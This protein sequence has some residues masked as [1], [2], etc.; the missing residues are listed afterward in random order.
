MPREVEEPTR[1]EWGGE[2][3]PAFGM[4]GAYRVQT[5][6]VLFQSDIRHQHTVVIT[7]RAATR[8]RDL[9]HDR[10]HAAARL[11]LMEVEMSEAQW[12]SFVSSM[13]VGDG[14]PC[15]IR[16]REG[17]HMVPGVPYQPRLAE[18][19]AEV[20]GAGAKAIEQVQAAFEAYRE[21][22]TAANLRTLEYAIKNMPANMTFAAKS[23]SEHAE[24]V[25]QRARADVEAMVLAKAAQLGLEPGDLGV[26]LPQLSAGD[27]DQTET[28]EN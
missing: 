2:Q 9:N 4:I 15:T 23:L 18:S 14:V 6:A 12:A 1:D 3:H 16:A 21:R 27:T 10:I 13:N 7:L 25:V 8:H 17:D 24:N 11:P 20:E 19:M 28:E 22:K 5:D 26:S